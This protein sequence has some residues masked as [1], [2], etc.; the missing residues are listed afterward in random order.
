MRSN[1]MRFSLSLLILLL[2]GTLACQ[3]TSGDAGQ[4]TLHYFTW[5]DYVGPELL[6]EFE[7]RHG[8]HV[9]V[10]TFSSN[11]ELLA[12]LQGGATGYD[13][14]VP[15]DFMAAIMI[16]QGLV[17]ELDSTMLPNAATLEDHLQ[18]LPFDP[19]QR[20]AIPYLWGTVGIG[21]DSAVVSPPPDSWAVLWDVRY[22]GKISMLNDQREVFGAVLRLIGT[23]MNTKDPALIEAAKARLLVQKP[24]VKAY[25]S[26]H[27]DQLLASGDVVLAHGWGGPVARAMLDRPSIR[28]VVPKEGATL[29]ADCLVVLKSSPRK[30]LATQ[31][32][33]YLLEPQVS[34]R[35]TERLLFASANK[36]ARPFVPSRILD[37]PAIYPPLDLLPR[38]EWMTDV[39]A[40]LRMYDRAWTELKMH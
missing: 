28:Y 24:L 11:E 40:A 3:R 10:D 26:E 38:L 7:R 30:K 21:Y 22:S 25:A 15:S 34:A 19:T 13:V 36:A 12:K 32:I 29:W 6:A 8:V 14:T 23:S 5:S 17:A 2:W 18:H 33:N 37:N 27:Y 9:V 20:F 16:Q 35:T 4:K 39:G 1:G 31:F